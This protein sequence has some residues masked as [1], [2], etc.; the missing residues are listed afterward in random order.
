MTYVYAC[1]HIATSKVIYR[2]NDFN[3][4]LHFYIKLDEWNARA[5]GQWQY[6]H[7]MSAFAASKAID[8]R[9]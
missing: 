6:W 1:L 5:R 9:S 4:Q 8:E 2:K 7:D 3:S